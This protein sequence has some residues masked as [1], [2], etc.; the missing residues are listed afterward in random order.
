MKIKLI[1]IIK[2]I[3]LIILIVSINALFQAYE[4]IFTN[5]LAMQ[6]MQNTDTSSSDIMLYTYLRNCS[7]LSVVLLAVVMF[8][9]EI[10]AIIKK[11]T[12]KEKNKNE[13]TKSK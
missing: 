10:K 7:W 9:S 2:I 5:E 11:Y 13:E 12:T 3:A 6:Q 4:P 1:T 8:W